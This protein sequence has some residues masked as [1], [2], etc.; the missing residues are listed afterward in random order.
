[1]K[2][3]VYTIIFILLITLCVLIGCGKNDESA[4][5]NSEI[6][7][8][9]NTDSMKFHYSDCGSAA[10]ISFANRGEYT[11]DRRVLIEEGFSPC[12]NCDP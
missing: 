7:Y 4:K 5:D 10:R 6:T 9:L 8:I 11:G 12:G 3:S 1:M 2:K